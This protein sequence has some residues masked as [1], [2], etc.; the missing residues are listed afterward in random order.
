MARAKTLFD[1]SAARLR[2]PAGI[3]AE[4]NRGLCRE[5]EAAML[6]TAVCGTLAIET[7][8]LALACAGHEPPMRLCC[9][10]PPVPLAIENGT[11]LGLFEGAVY[12]LN[13]LRL[14]RREAVVAFTDGVDEAFNPAAS[15]SAPSD[16]SRRS[17]PLPMSLPRAS[18][19]PCIW[20][21][22]PSP[23]ARSNRTTSRS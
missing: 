19:R 10:R 17:G 13:R 22:G 2:D 7:G 15:C 14:S 4:M 12:P 9:D 11:V 1:A 23:A 3:L 8:E 18:T 16:C 6:V 20:P 5:N 21:C